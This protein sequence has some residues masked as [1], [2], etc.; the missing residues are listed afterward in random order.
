MMRPIKIFKLS[1]AS[2]FILFSLLNISC[3]QEEGFGGN[4]HINGTLVTK[5]YNSDFSVYQG[6]APAIDQDVFLLFGENLTI[7]EDLAVSNYGQF[8][9]SY[10][11]PGSYQLYYM[12]DDTLS[13]SWDEISIS[14]NIE[15]AKN[16]TLS[17]DTLYTYK[18][19]DWDEGHAIIKGSV[20]MIDY[21]NES[22]YPNLVVKDTYPAQEQEIYLTYNHADFYQERIRTDENGQF[23][24]NNL[25]KGHYK[26]VV[27]S[28]NVQ[29]TNKKALIP[30][31]SELEI[32]DTFQQITMDTLTIEKF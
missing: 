32:T 9:F 15:L 2:L 16:E 23:V 30:V 5:F 26:I 6:E 11:W 14:L 27:Y 13:K 7:G 31:I 24:F 22:V 19:L 17:L 25:L 10:L 3:S 29:D 12:S 18:A 28:E 8:E 1:A 21:V 20:K 4:S